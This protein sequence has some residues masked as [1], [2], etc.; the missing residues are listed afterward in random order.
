MSSLEEYVKVKKKL[1]A[2]VTSLLM[3]LTLF[4]NSPISANAA[5]PSITPAA[6]TS[7][8]VVRSDPTITYGQ[9]ETLTITID[10]FD[11]TPVTN[12]I[13]LVD[14]VTAGVD[15]GSRSV[16]VSDCTPTGL[17]LT[18]TVVFPLLTPGTHNFI[19]T[20]S[21]TPGASGSNEGDVTGSTVVVTKAQSHIEISTSSPSIQ[22]GDAET[23][24]ISFWIDTPTAL[25]PTADSVTVNLDG[26][27]GTIL[28]KGFSCGSVAAN[29]VITCTKLVTGVHVAASPYTI[30]ATYNDSPYVF[31]SNAVQKSFT[32]TKRA[33][34]VELDL[35]N[36]ETTYGESRTP[37]ARVY[38]LDSNNETHAVTGDVVFWST[39]II[40]QETATHTVEIDGKARAILGRC[41]LQTSGNMGECR[42]STRQYGKM[43]GYRVDTITASYQGNDDFEVSYVNEIQ[44]VSKNTPIINIWNTSESSTAWDNGESS[45]SQHPD[46]GV[47]CVVITSG[48]SNPDSFTA[49]NPVG[50]NPEAIHTLYGD[51]RPLT[52]T[53]ENSNDTVFGPNSNESN[54]V[55]F[56][57]EGTVDLVTDIP[58]WNNTPTYLGDVIG[59][60]SQ[61]TLTRYIGYSACTVW[62]HPALVAGAHEIHASYNWG[63]NL[64]GDP[65]VTLRSDYPLYESATATGYLEV[66]RAPSVTTIESVTPG[67]ISTYPESV[68]VTVKVAGR[69]L[70]SYAVGNLPTVV[71]GLAPGNVVSAC[72]SGPVSI[73]GGCADLI[74]WAI[75]VETPTSISN[76]TTPYLTGI[77]SSD[78]NTLAIN[79]FYGCT[80]T[81][82]LH[83]VACSIE[84]P[85]NELSASDQH[86]YYSNGSDKTPYSLAANYIGDINYLPSVSV[87]Q[88][89]S[90]LKAHPT[91]SISTDADTSTIYSDTVTITVT[92]LGVAGAEAVTFGNGVRVTDTSAHPYADLANMECGN[93]S[94]AD[95]NGRSGFTCEIQTDRLHSSALLNGQ[96][97]LSAEY[98]GD[99]LYYAGDSAT[100]GLN[101]RQI[102]G[103]FKPSSVQITYGSTPVIPISFVE[104]GNDNEHP[105]VLNEDETN[106]EAFS[107]PT[108]IAINYMSVDI[109][110]G[111]YT[112]DCDSTTNG[113]SNQARTGYAWDYSF[114]YKKALLTTSAVT[115]SQFLIDANCLAAV[116]CGTSDQTVNI[117]YGQKASFE[118][119][120]SFSIGNPGTAP[121]GVALFYDNG[122]TTT[123]AGLV[124]P[125]DTSTIFTEPRLI[126]GCIIDKSYGWISYSGGL[127]ND[128]VV[129]AGVQAG[130]HNIFAYFLSADANYISRWSSNRVILNVEPEIPSV[131]FD[132]T[133]SLAYAGDSLTVV[134]TVS[135][136]LDDSIAPQTQLAMN[137]DNRIEPTGTVKIY[138]GAAGGGTPSAIPGNY[139][140]SCQLLAG[141]STASTCSTSINTVTAGLSANAT[142]YKLYAVYQGDSNHTANSSNI[143]SITISNLGSTLTL[144][145][146]SSTAHV[147]DID[148]VTATVTGDGVHSLAGV[149]I[150]INSRNGNAVGPITNQVCT[151]AETGTVLIA[152]CSISFTVTETGTIT[153]YGFA[154]N[155][156]LPYPESITASNVFLNALGAW[157][158][159]TYDYNGGTWVSGPTTQRGYQSTNLA[160]PVV[161]MNGFDFVGWTE[162]GS[163]VVMTNYSFAAD[164]TV[165][166]KWTPTPPAPVFTGGGVV[167]KV[168]P[169]LSWDNPAEITTTTPL[170][171]AQLN[172]VV[173]TPAGLAGTY[174]YSPAAGTL[175]P[176]GTQTL[177][178]TFTP[179][180]TTNYSA[181]SKT[182]SIVVTAAILP[183][184]V[185][186]S[187]LSAV[188]D[189]ASHSVGATT[190]PAGLSVAITYNGSSSAP[191]NAGTYSVVA[192][193]TSTGYKGSSNATLTI[194]K[195]TPVITWSNPASVPAGSSLSGAQLNATASV[196]GTFDYSPAAGSSVSVGSNTLDATFTPSDSTNYSSASASVDLIGLAQS[197]SQN[198]AITFASGSSTISKAQLTKVAKIAGNDGVTITIVGYVQPSKNKA[199]DLRLS[200]ARANAAKAQILKLYPDAKIVVVAKGSTINKACSASQNRCVLISAK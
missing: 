185:S 180:N 178:V 156:P 48:P 175:L 96:R 21:P 70:D 119:F 192:T 121:K 95:S 27:T 97:I 128:C 137:F 174:S 159:V 145:L 60:S 196:P 109:A 82:V 66:F 2:V 198:L 187:G 29:G 123:V 108:C 146:D 43:N 87:A 1:N 61:C 31:G 98:L 68:T 130:V 179:T 24:T 193:I 122:E 39:D 45:F 147:G 50:C 35:V 74:G 36:N 151:P 92:V 140:G 104:P 189:G 183:A 132:I 42:I 91:I 23:I 76:L 115:S 191:V 177:S 142:P 167:T 17:R 165:Y 138:R 11:S 118:A 20:Y 51:L 14:S 94:S 46:Y 62:V 47:G 194:S 54:P 6:N 55:W 134:A 22:Y 170:S 40:Y 129:E 197:A 160:G 44:N 166:A 164:K 101:I 133:Q 158:T 90:V 125:S 75:G 136:A 161:T 141:S 135:R 112:I 15:L 8:G 126:A 49:I 30:D 114:T 67:S 16:T 150:T 100:V 188:Y 79:G 168:T 149:Q 116:V 41:T 110:N 58:L 71:Y 32:I 181:V 152:T 106:A 124:T 139:V 107:F 162:S 69:E 190:S 153:F 102:P 111:V 63:A 155:L 93:V 99:A 148:T 171:G 117:I 34:Y 38:Y 81:A 163:A 9:V 84:I 173:T 80:L 72:A 12:D 157:H 53:V 131:A 169:V 33:T 88:D 144:S 89:Q 195:A 13:S 5:D 103:V 105:W 186:V 7:V 143:D 78:G 77:S 176:A 28:S 154:N 83:Q 120:Y 57:P 182:V 85:F 52:V 172:A 200:L 59:Y 26:D 86:Q 65:G 10:G 18:C 19:A 3:A 37:I 73:S 184:T 4:T 127:L 64:L 113:Q 25:T 199:T 56:Q